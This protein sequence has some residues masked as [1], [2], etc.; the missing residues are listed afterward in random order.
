MTTAAEERGPWDTESGLID[1]VDAVIVNA[2]FGVKEEYSQVVVATSG[3]EQKGAMILFD[4][5]DPSTQEVIGQQ[6]YSIG[7]GWEISEDGFDITHAKRKNVVTGTLYGQLQN[8]VVKDL[9]VD[10]T[11]RGLPTHAPV[12]EGL[13]FH[14]NLKSH[15]T[16]GGTDK[17]GLMPSLYIG[18]EGEAEAPAPAAPV[19]PAPAARPAVAPAR[20]A[21][22]RRPAKAVSAGEQAAIDLVASS[23]DAKSFTMKAVKVNAISSDDAL[24]SQVLDDSAAGFFATHKGK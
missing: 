5:K 2:H 3:G 10:M 11:P 7:T 4:L 23:A 15:A 8:I 12:W 18:V 19:A 17:Q 6:G 20:P 1:D 14:W 24:M 21:A 16:V 13:L 9:G 22:A